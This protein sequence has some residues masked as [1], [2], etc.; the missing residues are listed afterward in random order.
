MKPQRKHIL[1]F[2]KNDP[3]QVR[4]GVLA[5]QLIFFLALA[6]LLSGLTEKLPSLSFLLKMLT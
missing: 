6:A 4:V 5:M 1:E 2:F 3:W